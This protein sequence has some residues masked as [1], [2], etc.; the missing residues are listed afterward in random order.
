MYKRKKILSIDVK[1]FS[2]ISMLAEVEWENK[3][4]KIEN[5]AFKKR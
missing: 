5:Q 1:L 2:D 3:K 4:L